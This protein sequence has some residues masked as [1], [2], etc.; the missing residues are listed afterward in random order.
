MSVESTIVQMAKSARI[1]SFEMARCSSDKKN[2]A[3]NKIADKIEE[4]AP[5]IKE[6]NKNNIDANIICLN[7]FL[8]SIFIKSLSFRCVFWVLIA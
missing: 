5:A 1:A 8:F 6:E 3:L 7:F 2:M 4:N